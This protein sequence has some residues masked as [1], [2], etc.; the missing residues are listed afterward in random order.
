MIEFH[1]DLW[2]APADWRIITVNGTV[3]R[4]GEAVM[5]RGCARQASLRY[6]E[7][8]WEL[9][10]MLKS[11]PSAVFVFAHH[12]LITFPVKYE[13]YQKADLQLIKR[14]VSEL[15]EIIETQ[16]VYAMTR[17]GCNNGKLDWHDVKPLVEILP[18][19]VHVWDLRR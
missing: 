8:T 5:G 2:K 3:K 15:L 17:P 9:G 4:N 16:Y 12:K 10:Q 13:W 18:N 1:G 14:S 6:P 7:L 19:N 11:K